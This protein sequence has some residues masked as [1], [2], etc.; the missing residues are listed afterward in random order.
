MAQVVE[1]L[2]GHAA[3]ER[4]VADHRHDPTSGVAAQVLGGGQ[5]VGVGQHGG[6]V[7]VLDPVVVGLGP[8]RVAR[9]T[10]RAGGGWR[11]FSAAGDQLVHVGLMPGVPQDDVVGR[12]EDPVQR[13]GELDVAEVRTQVAAVGLD[14]LDDDLADLR[15]ELG[16]AHR[17]SAGEGQRGCRSGPAA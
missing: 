17:R 14:G 3:G 13:Q 8:R 5:A 16:R 12:V 15:G 7:A 11:T 4:S 10:R 1:P 2:V 6:G 9:Q